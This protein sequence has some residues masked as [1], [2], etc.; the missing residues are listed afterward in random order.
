MSSSPSRLITECLEA[1]DLPNA[2]QTQLANFYAGDSN[3]RTGVRVSAKDIDGK[4]DIITSSKSTMNAGTEV[5]AYLAKG[6]SMSG[7]GETRFRVP[8]FADF[9][10]GLY[11]G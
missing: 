4:A 11:V 1:R 10:G 3:D 2:T 5:N 9:Q 8:P 6:I 7:P